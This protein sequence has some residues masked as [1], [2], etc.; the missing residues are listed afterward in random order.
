MDQN[1]VHKL[2]NNICKNKV[3]NIFEGKWLHLNSKELW[4]DG[5]EP[6]NNRYK[7]IITKK[8]KIFNQNQFYRA[9]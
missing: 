8:R 2:C 9:L 1:F 3:F 5:T 7:C 4:K 6:F